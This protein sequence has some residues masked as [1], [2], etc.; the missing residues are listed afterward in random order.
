[1]EKQGVKFKDQIG[2]A[3]GSLGQR[4]HYGV[5]GSGWAY[6]HIFENVLKKYGNRVVV[7][8]DTPAT[9]ILV[10]DGK[11]IGVK[12]LRK[13]K[14]P[15]T[16]DAPSI[17]LATG[18]GSAQMLNIV[19]KL[20]PAFGRL[21]HSIKT[22]ARQTSTKQPKATACSLQK[23]SELMSLACLISSFIRQELRVQA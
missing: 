5:E 20:T 13:G 7:L 16:V 18:G 23:K 22:L 17:V 21:S 8:T 19:K 1:M 12:G 4:S 6:T 9:Q 15:V 11:V 3:T 2:A 14:Q 10:K